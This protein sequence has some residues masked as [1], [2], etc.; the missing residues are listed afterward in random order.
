MVSPHRNN[1]SVTR[2]FYL[3][4]INQISRFLHRRCHYHI[5][6]WRLQRALNGTSAVNIARL[7][8]IEVTNTQPYCNFIGCLLRAGSMLFTKRN[9]AT[10]QCTSVWTQAS[11]PSRKS[12]ALCEQKEVGSETTY[13]MYLL[14]HQLLL[15]LVTLAS[16]SYVERRY[17]SFVDCISGVRKKSN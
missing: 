6:A 3:R 5:A 16:V 12:T 13:T 17:I 15:Q 1:L 8:R 2:C 14:F 4:Y 9:T 10:R 7:Q 11:I